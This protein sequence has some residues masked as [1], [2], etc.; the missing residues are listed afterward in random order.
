MADENFL[1]LLVA[2]GAMCL[3]HRWVCKSYYLQPPGNHPAIFWNPILAGILCLGPQVAFVL[4]IVAAFFVTESPWW[5]LVAAFMM[6]IVTT[7]AYP[8]RRYR[9]GEG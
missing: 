1:I 4:I 7:P 2:F 5:F 6:L 9:R 3:V 8:R